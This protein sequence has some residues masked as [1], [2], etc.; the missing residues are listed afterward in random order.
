MRESRF[1]SVRRLLSGT[2]HAAPA[3][4]EDAGAA[5]PEPTK[6]AGSPGLTVEQLDAAVAAETKTASAEATKQ[7]NAR[8]NAVM[9][10]DAGIANPK[11][12]AR[13]LN[14]TSMSADDVQATLADLTPAPAA[15]AGQQQRQQNATDRAAL[16]NDAD[17]RPDTGGAASDAGTR[18]GEGKGTADLSERRAARAKRRN[19][20]EGKLANGDG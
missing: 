7:A 20:K 11:A 4:D 1:A 14:T 19:P 15:P 18:R 9:T 6:T 13:L 16:A 10:S 8:W 12:A 2:A 17:A 3:E 5:S